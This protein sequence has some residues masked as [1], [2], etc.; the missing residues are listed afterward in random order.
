MTHLSLEVGICVY[1]FKAGLRTLVKIHRFSVKI[2]SIQIVR[3]NALIN[4][5]SW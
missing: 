5:H 2:F 3:Y 1:A 4:I